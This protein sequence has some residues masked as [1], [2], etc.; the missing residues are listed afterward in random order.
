MVHAQL[1][2]SVSWLTAKYLSQTRT[3]AA[4]VSARCSYAASWM[5]YWWGYELVHQ[6]MLTGK[7]TWKVPVLGQWLE[8]HYPGGRPPFDWFGVNY[9]SRWDNMSLGR[10][11][12]AQEL[13]CWCLVTCSTTLLQAIF[14]NPQLPLGFAAGGGVDYPKQS[15]VL[16]DR[17]STCR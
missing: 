8:W 1:H 15:T 17:P 9:Y 13:V 7:F 2:I 14:G 12:C 5:N 6:F 11:T 16:G 10:T 3:S 4:A